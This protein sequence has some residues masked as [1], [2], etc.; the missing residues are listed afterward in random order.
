M[1]APSS[2]G[3]TSGWRSKPAPSADSPPAHV[4]PEHFLPERPVVAALRPPVVQVVPDAFPRQHSRER[5][6]VTA[7]LPRTGAGHNPQLAAGQLLV[8]PRIVEVGDV[9]DGI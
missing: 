2:A 8:K 5:V 3:I 6:R 7:L 1:R 9:V 4:I